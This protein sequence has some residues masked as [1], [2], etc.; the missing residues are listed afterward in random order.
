[1]GYGGVVGGVDGE[2]ESEEMMTASGGFGRRRFDVGI[3]GRA[4]IDPSLC[5]PSVSSLSDTVSSISSRFMF[6]LVPAGKWSR[7]ERGE[8]CCVAAVAFSVSGLCVE[9][10]LNFGA[11]VN[12]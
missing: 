10:K 3:V 2:D 12:C 5:S 6:G 9:L 11:G 8:A 4:N 1:M 7:R